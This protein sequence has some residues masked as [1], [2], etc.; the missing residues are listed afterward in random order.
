VIKR[1]IAL[2]ILFLGVIVGIYYYQNNRKTSVATITPIGIVTSPTPS[3]KEE[4]KWT[5]IATGDVIPARS[6]NYKTIL[7]KD[8]T[9]VWKNIAPLLKTGDITVINLES[10]LLSDC[11]MTN[12]GFTFCGDKRHIEGLVYAGVDV[13]TLANNHIGNYGKRGIDETV[14]LLRSNYI[15]VAGIDEEPPIR[16]VN[17]IRVGFFAYNDIGAKEEGVSWADTGVMEKEIQQLRN[18]VDVVVVSMSWG[19]EYTATPS[20]RQK[21]LAH[22]IIDSGADLVLGNHPHWTQPVEIYQGKYIVYAHGN[23]IFDQMWSEETKIGVIGKYT[24]SGLRLINI[25]FIPTYI[26]DYGQPILLTGAAKEKVLQKL[27][28]NL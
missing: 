23:T 14:K 6:V 4:N 16:G 2:C 13:A 3:E 5:L 18:K 22:V 28:T 15:D 19:V 10:P 20:A 21:E 7:Y 8:F 27:N 24:F 17:N 25:E 12:D 11:P 26:Q 9:W 1:Y